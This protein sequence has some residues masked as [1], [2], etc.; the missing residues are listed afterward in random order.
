MQKLVITGRLPSLNEYIDRCRRNRYAG[1]KFKRQFQE[2]V[3]WQIKIAKIEKVKK[4][5]IIYNFYEKN[6]R[7][8]KD[9]ISSFAR[10]VINDALQSSG[11]LENDNWECVGSLTDR[12]Y[13]DRENPRIEVEIYECD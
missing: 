12:F 7:R 5:N 2:Y 1:A 6:K 11:V 10:K 8:D 9:N 3:E 4:V 13:T